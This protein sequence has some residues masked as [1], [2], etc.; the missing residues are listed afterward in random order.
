MAKDQQE[1]YGINL[2]Q[3]LVLLANVVIAKD[4][5]DIGYLD[6]ETPLKDV[7]HRLEKHGVQIKHKELEA[8]LWACVMADE[9]EVFWHPENEKFSTFLYKLTNA[10]KVDRD[11]NEIYSFLK[12]KAKRGRP[13]KD[14]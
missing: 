7:Y 3:L 1:I 5:K 13:K 12:E 10:R 11:F 6:A 9:N 14:A 8:A 2:Y 4:N